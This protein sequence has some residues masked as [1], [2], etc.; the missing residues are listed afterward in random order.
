MFLRLLASSGFLRFLLVISGLRVCWC[1]LS[2]RRVPVAPSAL[3]GPAVQQQTTVHCVL[4]AP[5]SQLAREP[6]Q[7]SHVQM[8]HRKIS[9]PFCE[10]PIE[11]TRYFLH[12]TIE[13]LDGAPDTK[14]SK[15]KKLCTTIA[16]SRTAERKLRKNLQKKKAT[17]TVRCLLDQR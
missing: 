4:R 13:K 5:S 9:P 16:V 17:S 7:C 10:S 12:Y 1:F 15:L 14:I 8:L 6:D 2:S 11:P 3:P